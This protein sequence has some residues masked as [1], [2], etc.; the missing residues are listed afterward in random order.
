MRRQRYQRPA[1]DQRINEAQAMLKMRRTLEG[2]NAGSLS[3]QFNL[4][5]QTA[6]RLLEYERQRRDAA[7]ARSP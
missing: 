4:R 1:Q 2:L 3:C 5:L 7:E 6:D